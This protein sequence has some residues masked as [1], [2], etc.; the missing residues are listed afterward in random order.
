MK[1]GSNGGEWTRTIVSGFH[2]S[3]AFSEAE[4]FGLGYLTDVLSRFRQ[5]CP[6]QESNSNS[7]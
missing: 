4:T 2:S 5:V 1:G 3:P 6:M 7:F